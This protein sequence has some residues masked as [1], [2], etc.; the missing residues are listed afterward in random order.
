MI[1]TSTDCFSPGV[2]D[3]GC[4]CVLKIAF[5][6]LSDIAAKTYYK[7]ALLAC[8][9]L[10][11]DLAMTLEYENIHNPN[12]TLQNMWKQLTD[13]SSIGSSSP[14]FLFCFFSFWINGEKGLFIEGQCGV[15]WMVRHTGWGAVS[16]Q[17]EIITQRVWNKVCTDA[18]SSYAT[19]CSKPSGRARRVP[20]E[21]K[22][23]DRPLS[24]RVTTQSHYNHACFYPDDWMRSVFNSEMNSSVLQRCMKCTSPIRV[25]QY[26]SILCSLCGAIAWENA[27]I[28]VLQEN[29]LVQCYCSVF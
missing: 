25:R 1:Y 21:T 13:S 24:C 3:R 29:I 15:V 14:S 18:G 19:K 26:G 16:L 7:R 5:L 12:G 8:Y 6:F 22:N 9:N 27:S 23:N 10:Y 11:G 2:D 4:E 28:M 17:G 20:K